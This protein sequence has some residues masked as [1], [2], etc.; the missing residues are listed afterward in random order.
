[1][2]QLLQSR[3]QPGARMSSVLGKV[4]ALNLLLAAPFALAAPAAGA[5]A[6]GTAPVIVLT[7]LPC[8][9]VESEGGID[10]GYRSS[11][12]ED[13]E[14]INAQ[15]GAARVQA[16]KPLELKPGPY[17]FRVTNKSVP[18]ELGFWLRGAGVAGRVTLPSVSGGGL[19]QG[20]TQD[21]EIVLKPGEYVYSCPLNT[22]PDY[23]LVV[24]K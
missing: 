15:S 17:V 18:Y 22:T 23:R 24:K 12:Q 1:M 10:R 8:Q 20:V 14:R 5:K 21:Y 7:Q 3:R 4:I 11:K 2:K 19:T 6:A 9:F 16:A 13:C